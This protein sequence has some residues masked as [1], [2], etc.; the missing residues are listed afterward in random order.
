MAS[1]LTGCVNTKFK[2]DA[3]VQSFVAADEPYAAGIGRDILAQGGRAGDAVAAMALAMTASLP[4]RVG[5]SG[6]GVC[7]LFDS[8]SKQARTVDFL[9]R[10]ASAGGAA[11]PAM[12]R[13]L[14][15]VKASVGVLRW[16]QV[17]APAE[18]L[19]Q[20]SPGLSRALVQDLER[21]GGRLAPESEA[22]RRFLGNGVPSVGAVVG[23][24][25]LAATLS[26]IRREGVGAFYAGPLSATVAQGLGLDPAA[27][28]AYQPRVA[29]TLT[30]PFDITNLHLPDL[31]VPEAGAALVKTW[32]A[33]AGL[34]AGQRVTR[35]AQ[36]LGATGSGPAAAGAG[37]VVIDQDENGAA[38]TFTQGAPF[39]SG[40]TI[41]GTG[42]LVAQGVE[43]GGFGTPALIANSIVG[44]TL[45]AAAGTATGDDGPAAG[46]AALLS[47]ALPAALDDSVTAADIQS[48]RPQGLPGRV[49][50]VGCRVS[51]EDGV[52]YCQTA[53]DPKAG[54]LALTA[55]SERKRE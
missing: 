54:A 22:R 6:G 9:P 14:Y 8:A 23:Q 36:L 26:L 34:P 7:V 41:P 1:L 37:V 11:M 27:L 47:A 30:V 40:R 2:T 21:F 12:L 19:A 20:F 39:G 38:C 16:E 31:P 33:V 25:E 51:R 18:Q 24:P 45:F 32:Q 42:M 53:A 52:R 46:P 43:S 17:V 10:P 13:G 50:F 55:E 3:M 29:G 35:A 48:S 15:A 28:R 5:L 44:R 49:S 4:S